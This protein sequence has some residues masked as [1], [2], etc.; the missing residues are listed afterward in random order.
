MPL[1]RTPTKYDSEES[2]TEEGKRKRWGPDEE[3]SSDSVKKSK[4]SSSTPEKKRSPGTTKSKEKEDAKLDQVL[5]LLQ[6]LTLEVNQIRQDQREYNE[7]IKKLKLENET[8]K[9]EN[10]AITKECDEIKKEL[11]ET[12]IRLE[13]LEREKRR[14]NVVITGLTIAN[15]NTTELKQEMEKFIQQ[16]LE[17]SVPVQTAYKIGPKM[18]IIKLQSFEDKIQL[19]KN[20]MKLRNMRGDRIFI[21]NDLSRKEREIDKQI[22]KRAEAEK[23]QG[24]T[25]KIGYQKLTIEGKEWKWDAEKNRLEENKGKENPIANTSKN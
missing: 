4:K 25:V 9:Q 17:M 8:R 12:N 16:K 22:R 23:N 20:K 6:N 21:N 7:E 5:S 14:N 11:R 13:Q 19:M 2:S 1:P 24:K 18:C 10:S 15:S 3:G